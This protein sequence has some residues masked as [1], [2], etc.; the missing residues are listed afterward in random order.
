MTRY[1][2]FLSYSHRNR[3]ETEWLHRALERY[4]IPKKLVGKE[5]AKGPVPARLIPIFR[6]RDELSASADLG[7]ELRAALANSDHL[8]VVAS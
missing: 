1:V 3:A 4:H 5:T 8:V 2:A 7:N 6:D